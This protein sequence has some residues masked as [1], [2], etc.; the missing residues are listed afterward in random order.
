[1]K[2]WP[3]V[4][5]STLA[6]AA[7]MASDAPVSQ[8]APPGTKVAIGVNVRGLLDS[9]LAKDL[10][11]QERDIAAKM[12]A[13]GALKG[14]D[15]LKDVDQVMLLSTGEGDQPP[16]LVILRGRFDVDKLAQ[17]ASRYHDVPVLEEG[18][19][20]RTAMGLLDGETA[21]L[22]ETAQVRAAIDRLGS[23]AQLDA[24]LM[25]RIETARSQYDIWGIGDCPDGLGAPAPGAEALRSID[26]FTFGAALRQG[27]QLT[28]EVHARSTE[29]AAKMEAALSMLEAA[30]KA[31][32]PKDSAAEF[33]LHSDNGTFQVSL[34]V[35]EEELRKGIEAQ[36]ASLAAAVSRHTEPAMPAEPAIAPPPPEAALPAVPEP[37]TLPVL[38]AMTPPAPSVTSLQ[39]T[40]PEV[41]AKVPASS[42]PSL[43]SAEPEMVATAPAPPRV[44]ARPASRTEIVKAPNGDTIYVKLPGAK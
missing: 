35:P 12:T 41:V 24:G 22:G 14:I 38:E 21:I 44:A 37:A 17:G 42:L 11:G 39:H 13:A 32:Q 18:S 36:R 7:A 20:A 4:F 31:R 28:A 23:D 5:I 6:A 26:R 2:R 34:V 29:D 1:M 25:S 16:T 27:L 19:G 8:L 43:P 40:H 10:G 3:V 9:P 15:P 33:A 30:L